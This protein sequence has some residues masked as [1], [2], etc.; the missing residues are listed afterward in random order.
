[1]TRSPVQL[2]HHFDLSGGILC[3]DFA[4][5]VSRRKIPGQTIDYLSEYS[6][7]VMFAKQSRVVTSQD[8]REL[9]AAALLYPKD[10]VQ[11][12]RAAG[13]LREAVYRTFAAMASRRPVRKEDLD[14]IEQFAAEAMH[15]R[16]LIGSGRSYRWEWKQE[17]GEKGALAR[18]L[19]PIAQSAADLLTS[20]RVAKVRECQAPTCAWLFLDESRNHSRRWCDMS[21]CGNRQKA[22][23][24]Y[25]RVHE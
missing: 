6:D 15:H 17:E 19:W 12:L 8:A 1:M 24:H 10:A 21:V 4:N 9:I 3:L 22:R 23:R 18:L 2:D 11:I 14:L 16:H 7:L 13:V 5:T 25:K 20:D